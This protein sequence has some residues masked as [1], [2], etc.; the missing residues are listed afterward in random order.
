ML[1]RRAD[2]RT[3]RAMAKPIRLKSHRMLID[4]PCEMV[5]Q[6][7]SSFGKGRLQGDNNETSKVISRD[8][9]TIIAEFRTKAGPFRYTTTEEITLEA[10][11]RITFRHLSGPLR[12]AWEEFVFSDVDGKT[13]LV[14][15]GEFIW[16]HVPIL[17]WLGR[18]IYT[19]PL[20]EHA[21]SKHME[22]IRVSCEARAARS[23][24]FG[25]RTAA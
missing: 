13:E 7:M 23:H 11:E 24:V 25:K 19:R 5:F 2:E 22:Q 9:D 14:H 6:K 1:K 3:D 12:Y 15:N 4:A 8:G 20:F 10:P 21:I 16:S 17:G 18:R